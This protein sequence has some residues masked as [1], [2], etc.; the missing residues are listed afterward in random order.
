MKKEKEERRFSFPGLIFTVFLILTV[1]YYVGTIYNLGYVE[2]YESVF[3]AIK[4]LVND[5][6]TTTDMGLWLSSNSYTIKALGL[7]CIGTL[8][9]VWNV[10]S[11]FVRRKYRIWFRPF[12][13]LSFFLCLIIVIAVVYTFPI[14][15]KFPVFGFINDA[16][17]AIYLT[18]GIMWGRMVNRISPEAYQSIL[19]FLDSSQYIFANI[20]TFYFIWYVIF[21]FANYFRNLQI[22]KDDKAF[23]K[24][25]ETTS[26]YNLFS[27][28]ETHARTVDKT[29]PKHIRFF[30]FDDSRSNAFAYGRN[31]IAVFS[32]ALERE[33][34][35][36]LKGFLAHEM[37]HLAHKDTEAL[38]IS[39]V[40]MN[41]LLFII[42]VPL[43]ITGLVVSSVGSFLPIVG[44]VISGFFGN[45]FQD[46][47][48]DAIKFLFEKTKKAT[49]ILGGRRDETRA[50]SFAAQCGYGEALIG[51]FSLDPDGGGKD[52]HPKNSKRIENI[53]RVMRKLT[54]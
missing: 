47:C 2:Y 11:F 39:A 14:I 46:K 45:F 15:A 50:D 37:G 10:L 27:E 54:P 32:G 40:C 21:R 43:N 7:W 5:F 17:H 35:E 28:V 9:V 12:V 26:I 33:S 4:N 8:F 52:E 38:Q 19:G 44:P 13:L 41:F 16:I 34:P 49:R 20:G 51:F 22:Q 1:I 24:A 23:K 6:L 3:F 29:L 25:D 18:T 48:Q 31:R 42:L 36:V 30:I 53:S